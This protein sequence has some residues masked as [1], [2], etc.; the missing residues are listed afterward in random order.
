MAITKAEIL[1][2]VN[3][4]TQ[5][6]LTSIDDYLAEALTELS[7]RIGCFKSEYSGTLTGSSLSLQSK[8]FQVDSFMIGND[9]PDKI[10]LSEYHEDFS[11]YA[12]DIDT[13]HLYLYPSASSSSYTIWYRR[14]T[15]DVD[16]I[17]FSDCWKMALVY[18]VAAKV[19]D[20]YELDDDSIKML[21]KYEL[22]I[23]KNFIPE[24]IITKR[25]V[26]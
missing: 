16:N 8:T 15:D 11:G 22:E 24:P 5:R 18:L 9:Y 10:S 1:A 19:Y 21:N 3:Q 25:R 26:S 6:E 14:Y 23:A 4:R 13:G 12:I 2:R 17:E 20:D 7:K